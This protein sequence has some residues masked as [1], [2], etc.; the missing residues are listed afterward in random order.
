MHRNTMLLFDKY[1]RGYFRPGVR[2]LEI[3]PDFDSWA[4]K[5][6]NGNCIST[7]AC[8]A[9]ADAEC[10][11]TV[12]IYR[13]PRLTYTATSEYTFPIEDNRYDLVLSANVMEH[14]RKPWVW[15]RE[16]ARVCKPGGHVIT[17]VPASW[18][19]HEAPYDCWRAYPE[20]MKALY[21]DARLTVVTAACEAL[22]DPHLKRHIP[23][24]SQ[25]NVRD[26]SSPKM[27]AVTRLLTMI[28]Y[29]LETAYDTVAIG[30]KCTDR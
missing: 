15:I 5:K 7:F 8:L 11:D 28:G 2:V 12:D 26:D 20:G 6:L 1:A 21:S 23:G 10:W 3:G 29:P 18:P 13:S 27:R 9:G 22:G 19:Y 14:V 25:G 16:L 30:R 24:R 4:V 17:I